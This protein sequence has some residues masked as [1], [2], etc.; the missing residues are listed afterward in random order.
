LFIGHVLFG[1]T[2]FL[3]Y[4]FFF[5]IFFLSLFPTFVRTTSDWYTHCAS[6]VWVT[7]CYW[8][9][10]RKQ[11]KNHLGHDFSLVRTPPTAYSLRPLTLSLPVPFRLVHIRLQIPLRLGGFSSTEIKASF[12]DSRSRSF[13]HSQNTSVGKEGSDCDQPITRP[14]GGKLRRTWKIS[15]HCSPP[16][17][18]GGLSNSPSL[19]G[20]LV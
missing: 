12:F 15:T 17:E 16:R 6:V 3:L 9:R 19:S 20:L 2:F 11:E 13:H 10:K 18:G 7:V 14:L 8:G 1:A 4:F 5:P